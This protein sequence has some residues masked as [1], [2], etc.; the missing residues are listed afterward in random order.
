LRVGAVTIVLII[1]RFDKPSKN[2]LGDDVI[3]IRPGPTW[4]L[5]N[6]PVQEDAKRD[7]EIASRARHCS[8]GGLV[9]I[10]AE[11]HEGTS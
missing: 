5:A 10:Q 1:G 8:A 7:A 3:K 11:S 9:N 4:S 2:L 6:K